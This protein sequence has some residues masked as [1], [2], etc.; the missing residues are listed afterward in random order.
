MVKRIMGLVL[1]LVC[2]W[3]LLRRSLDIKCQPT[4]SNPGLIL[5]CRVQQCVT[6]SLCLQRYKRLGRTADGRAVEQRSFLGQNSS[7]PLY[8][9][10]HNQTLEPGKSFRSTAFCFWIFK[11]ELN[12]MFLCVFTLRCHVCGVFMSCD[13]RG[14]RDDL[15]VAFTLYLACARC[16]KGVELFEI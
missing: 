7:H 2:N 15:I 10:Q 8:S 1:W 13:C 6:N 12:C 3:A 9:T 11:S 14:V 5:W 4:D 16:S